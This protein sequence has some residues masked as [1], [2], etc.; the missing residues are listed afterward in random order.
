MWFFRKSLVSFDMKKYM[1]FFLIIFWKKN[2]FSANNF[3]RYID[4]INSYSHV[5]RQKI[6]SHEKRIK[7]IHHHT[8]PQKHSTSLHTYLT[9]LHLN[10]KHLSS[11]ERISLIYIAWPKHVRTIYTAYRQAISQK[12]KT[13]LCAAVRKLRTLPAQHSTTQQSIRNPYCVI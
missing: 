2:Y 11:I 6:R 7:S 1:Q 8:G 5:C 3:T 12:E 13:L 4:K 9:I 10:A